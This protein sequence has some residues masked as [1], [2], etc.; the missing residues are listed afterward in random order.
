LADK[1]HNG[2]LNSYSN[3]PEAFSLTDLT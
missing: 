1:E 2:L 3:N